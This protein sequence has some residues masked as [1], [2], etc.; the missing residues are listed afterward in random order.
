MRTI[1]REE[2]ED[3]NKKVEEIKNEKIKTKFIFLYGNQMFLIRK[4]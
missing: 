4:I 1:T 3:F 2:L